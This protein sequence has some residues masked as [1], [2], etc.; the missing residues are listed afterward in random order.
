MVILRKIFSPCFLVLSLSLLIYTF[1]RSEIYWNGT[2]NEYYLSYYVISFSC[3]VI[4][5]LTFFLKQNFKDYLLIILISILLALY[6][7][8]GYAIFDKFRINKNALN[9]RAEAYKKKEKKNYDMRSAFEVYNDLKKADKKVVVNVSPSYYLNKNLDF[10][11]LSSVSNSKTIYCNENGYWVIYKS[12]RF[13]FN[14]PDD[15]WDK[16]KIEYAL[17]GDSF[18]FGACVNS[19]NDIASVL[20][21]LSNKPVLN[22][23]NNGVGPLSQYATLR[24]Y[25]VPGIRKVLW[26]YYE[27]NDLMNLNNELS[28]EILKSYLDDKNFKQ[29]LME[30]QTKV[31]KFAR[32]LIEEKK[33]RELNYIKNFIKLKN[34]RGALNKFLPNKNQPNY[35]R[36]QLDLN[37]NLKTVLTLTKK[38]VSENKS[39]LYFIYLP[40]YPRYKNNYDNPNYFAVKKIVEDL[41]IKIIDIHEKVFLRHQNPLNLFP[42]GLS[43]HYNEEGYKKVGNT[44][45]N[46]TKN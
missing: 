36:P 11:P 14:N 34:V 28:D 30:N 5:I 46:F 39:Q 19:P 20:K 6:I 22:L 43:G 18:G 1:Y 15:I 27:G 16:E 7:F 10:Y 42:F 3:I 4:S 38:L 24:E 2:K 45:Y 32:N 44:I 37:D 26:L 23:S 21:N 33:R 29:D 13:G 41:D 35:F 17:I 31:D 12:D 40:E 8:E 25:L 9:E